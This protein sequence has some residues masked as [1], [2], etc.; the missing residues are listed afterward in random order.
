MSTC[1]AFR[2]KEFK[3]SN[4]GCVHPNPEYFG[5][6]R[7]VGCPD[8][9]LLLHRLVWALF[10]LACLIYLAVLSGK[11]LVIYLT[12]WTLILTTTSIL[13]SFFVTL[14][15]KTGHLGKKWSR[16]IAFTWVI[17]NAAALSST[18]ITILYWALLYQGPTVHWLN[19]VAH[20]LN[21]LYFCLDVWLGKIPVR[22]YHFYHG[23][24]YVLIYVIFAAIYLVSGGTN[25]Q[26]QRIIYPV[27]DFLN[28][29]GMATGFSV[30]V[31]FIGAVVWTVYYGMYLLATFT[32][33]RI[34]KK[35]V[36]PFGIADTQ[37]G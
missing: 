37:L 22:W 9:V 6:P 27:I 15:T 36:G 21:A 17:H 29:P 23:V 14:F 11:Y 18:T 2:A 13:L 8:I 19:V 31:L 5:K 33:Y 32:E 4:W 25:Q 12:N 10:F 20:G 3:C 35:Q 28:E 7:W 26:G 34:Y 24:V 16:F 30:A 1:R